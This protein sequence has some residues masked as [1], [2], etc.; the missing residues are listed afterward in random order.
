MHFI[1]FQANSVTKLVNYNYTS[2]NDFQ[3]QNLFQTLKVTTSIWFFVYVFSTLMTYNIKN[4]TLKLSC[5]YNYLS[6]SRQLSNDKLDVVNYHQSKLKI[7]Q[8][9]GISKVH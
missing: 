1:R 5:G 7:Y 2:F 6:F 8:T 9:V 3:L 4:L